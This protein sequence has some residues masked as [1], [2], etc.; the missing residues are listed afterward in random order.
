MS[1]HSLRA[2]GDTGYKLGH[3]SVR[4]RTP[5]SKCHHLMST[6]FSRAGLWHLAHFK[7]EE[8]T[9]KGNTQSHTERLMQ[10]NNFSSPA[11]LH[12]SSDC[13][14]HCAPLQVFLS[15]E[16]PIKHH[17]NPPTEPLSC[18]LPSR[19]PRAILAPG[20]TLQNPEVGDDC[21][22]LLLVLSLLPQLLD[23]PTSIPGTSSSAFPL[24]CL[25]SFIFIF[26]FSSTTPT[27]HFP[28]FP[29]SAFPLSLTALH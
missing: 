9:E 24:F 4:D 5:H 17:H 14:T 12:C 8:D 13:A 29:S 2:R 20:S 22:F 26:L 19:N 21:T 27:T 16:R 11:C 10:R 1:W 7:A 15:R 6:L 23:L 28:L 18:S 3:L 25:F